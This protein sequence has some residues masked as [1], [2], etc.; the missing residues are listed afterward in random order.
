MSLKQRDRPWQQYMKDNLEWL[1]FTVY[2][3]MDGWYSEVKMSQST[4]V[5]DK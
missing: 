2:C 4:L 1:Y 3:V 5:E